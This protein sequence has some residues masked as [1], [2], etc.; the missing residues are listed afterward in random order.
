MLVTRDRPSADAADSRHLALLDF[1]E[2]ETGVVID[3]GRPALINAR[4]R[5]VCR[6]F[7]VDPDEA[8]AQAAAAPRGALGQALIDALTNHETWFFRD[9]HPFDTLREHVVPEL[10]RSRG[11]V[12]IWCAACATGQEALSVA[13]ALDE[14][15][16]EWSRDRLSIVATDVSPAAISRCKAGTYS[17]IE[18][19]RGLPDGRRKKWFAPDGEG[20]KAHDHLLDRITYRVEN[21][22]RLEPGAEPFDVV[23]LR[24]VTIYFSDHTS[25]RVLRSV[26]DRMRPGGVLFMGAGESPPELLSRELRIERVGRTTMWR[27]TEARA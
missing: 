9:G 14:L 20:W 23:L 24:H 8:I 10:L 2:S 21:L 17:A 18:L 19:D 11:S 22:L 27:R 1:V 12:R 6:D 3:T 7:G 15:D 13:M 25:K 4:L 16:D 5:P 26:V